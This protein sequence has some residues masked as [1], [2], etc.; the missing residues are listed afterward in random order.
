[1]SLLAPVKALA[2]TMRARAEDEVEMTVAVLAGFESGAVRGIVARMC[3][4]V[5]ELRL[6]QGNVGC[7]R[8]E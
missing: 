5:D 8:V 4:A 7:G 6:R 3:G 2:G 1:M